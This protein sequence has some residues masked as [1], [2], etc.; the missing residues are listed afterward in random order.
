MTRRSRRRRGQIGLVRGLALLGVLVLLVVALD[1]AEHIDLVIVAVA[2]VAGGFAA[3][4][5]WERRP[6]REAVRRP[7]R[8]GLLRRGMTL[9]A[10]PGARPARYGAAGDRTARTEVP[11]AA[12]AAPSR[13][14]Q[15]SPPQDQPPTRPLPEVP[16]V[17][18]QVALLEQLAG[19]PIGAIIASYQVI[20][21]Q[22]GG[23]S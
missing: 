15:P 20:Q 11:R 16:A 21:R 6:R 22:Y 10:G 8:A 9:E 3:G 17:A 13:G 5:R 4:R 18:D 19:R 12:G 14:A 2:F 1:M 7:A 23:R